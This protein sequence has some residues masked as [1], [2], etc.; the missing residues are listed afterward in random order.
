MKRVYSARDPADAHHIRG[1]LETNDVEAVVQGDSLWVGRGGLPLTL[2][3]QP[4]VWV[5]NDDDYDRARSLIVGRRN[6]GAT[7]HC[8]QCGYNLTGL[9]EPRCP[10]CGLSFT[11]PSSWVFCER[12]G[13]N[14]TGLMEPACPACG[15][16]LSNPSFWVCPTCGERIENQF[17]ECWKCAAS[18]DEHEPNT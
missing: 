1:Y 3:T 16:T 14:V 5:V 6:R 9:S 4:S 11:V 10:E 13:H 7:F 17:S 2:D 12:C 8:E 15:H 18:A